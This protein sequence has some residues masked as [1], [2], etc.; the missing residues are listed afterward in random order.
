MTSTTNELSAP[1]LS[2]LPKHEQDADV[3]EG[4]MPCSS[5][6]SVA[7]NDGDKESKNDSSQYAWWFENCVACVILPALLFLQF[8]MTF[9][10]WCRVGTTTGLHWYLVN[11]SIVMF[12]II[13]SL[14][15]RAIKDRNLTYSAVLLL[16]EILVS[17]VMDLV[18]FGKVLSAFLILLSSMLCLAVFVGVSMGDMV[19]ANISPEDACDEQLQ[20]DLAGVGLEPVQ[21]M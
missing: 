9:Y 19:V 13:A 1:F 10:M 21:T 3:G 15:R 18:L 2:N 4:C 7:D 5:L 12:V 6:E 16:P 17:I 8:S 20:D 11:Y 14:Y